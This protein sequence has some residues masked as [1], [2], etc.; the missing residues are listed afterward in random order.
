MSRRYFPVFPDAATALTAGFPGAVFNPLE[1]PPYSRTASPSTVSFTIPASS[2]YKMQV[3]TPLP[4][5]AV[6]VTV[7]GVARTLSPSPT[8]SSGQY[9][10]D[11]VE[12]VITF[13]SA[14]AGGTA[15]VTL[16]LMRMV[17]RHDF[18]MRIQA[19]IAAAQ[20]AIGTVVTGPSS[21]TDNAI[22]RFD[23]TTGKLV[24]NSLCTIDDSGTITAVGYIGGAA[25]FTSTLQVGGATTLESSLTEIVIDNSANPTFIMKRARAA[26]TIVQDT[27]IVG[28]WVCT[29]FDGSLYRVA[30]KI[31]CKV[32]G[33]PGSGDMPGQWEFYTT[34]DGSTTPVLRLT[35]APSGAVTVAGVFAAGG[36]AN[37]PISGSTGAFTS[38]T[39]S[40]A[41]TFTGGS[42]STR[43]TSNT[44]ATGSELALQ[45]E[46]TGSTIVSFGDRLGQVGFYGW[47]GSAFIAGAVI[48]AGVTGTPGANDM[49]SNL[50]FLT[51]PDGSAT[52]VVI[53]TLA[54]DGSAAFSYGASFGGDILT[55][56]TYTTT[57]GASYIASTSNTAA[58]GSFLY[59][60]RDHT[61]SAI[62][63]SG[64]TLGE[65]NFQGWDGAAWRT[66][67]IIRAKVSAT[68]GSSDMP[69]KLEIWTTP[70][71][72]AT[73]VLAVTVGSDGAVELAKG[74]TVTESLTV[75]GAGG[76]VIEGQLSCQTDLAVDGDANVNGDATVAGRAIF[77]PSAVQTIDS[78][79]DT[80]LANARIVQI[81]TDGSNYILASTPTIADGTNGQ[82]ITIF[83][84]DAT[85]EVT[86]QTEGSLAGS[87]LYLGSDF[88]LPAA[89]GSITLVFLT[90]IGGW[91][92]TPLG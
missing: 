12:G 59:L 22:T 19:E 34:P 66:A 37:T 31:V 24:Q 81:D 30:G 20:T 74:L 68:P 80:I 90:S 43:S 82:I 13:N 51:T 15:S 14:D 88:A 71:G 46:R 39:A 29:A 54:S 36:I 79:A 61:S 7:G 63:A 9:Y 57:G 26:T 60:R 1:F 91:V 92:R 70:D 8:P 83:N 53:L 33:S 76:A 17:I 62:V 4:Q 21:A 56:G 40:G 44:A 67:A 25:Q 42:Q 38:L 73:P 87:N 77:I 16:T 89:G 23:G 50:Q 41:V 84:V 55:S 72:S 69:G 49:P 6:T 35:I 52:P 11:P 27:D 65:I 5:A 2:P 58:N 28:E 3:G 64:D 48:R 32:N 10:L 45:R 47:D 86:L 18:L 75:N 85:R 78:T